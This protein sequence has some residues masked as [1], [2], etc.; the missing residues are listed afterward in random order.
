MP[1]CAG[2]S[3]VRTTKLPFNLLITPPYIFGET[4]SPG[5]ILATT[6]THMPHWRRGTPYIVFCALF[7]NTLNAH[8]EKIIN[9]RI[10]A[11]NSGLLPQKF[12]VA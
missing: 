1:V 4:R 11:A 7:T 2:K 3:P 9:T 5:M 12:N 8:H 10:K 6:S